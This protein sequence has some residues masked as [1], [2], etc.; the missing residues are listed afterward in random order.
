LSEA[1]FV[2]MALPRSRTAWLSVFLSYGAWRC[3]HER[4]VTMRAWGDVE[5]FFG[6]PRHGSVETGISPGWRLLEEAFPALRRAVVLRPVADAVAST[7]RLPIERIGARFDEARLRRN[8]A[9]LHRCLR[10]VAARPGVL[11]LSLAELDTEDGCRRLFEHCLP[12]RFDREW[13]LMLR[14]L[15][16]EQDALRH[17]ADALKNRPAID[18]FKSECWRRL[19]RLARE[20]A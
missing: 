17:I 19:R 20:T 16:I 3:S 2:V 12:Y 15:H 10:A 14:R 1:P 5:R 6:A 9:Y 13:W 8:Y 7:L 18:A 11:A 4:A